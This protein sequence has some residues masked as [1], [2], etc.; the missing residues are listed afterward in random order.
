MKIAICFYGLPRYSEYTLSTLKKYLLDLYDI[1][2]YAHLWWSN[3]MIG[4]YK[5]RSSED[6]WEADT[7]DILK[8]KLHFK[9][10][11]TEPQIKFDIS[12]CKP[13]SPEPDLCHLPEIICKDTIF[14][15]VSKW[16]SVHKAFSLIDNVNDYDFIIM[17]RLDSDYSGPIDLSKLKPY[18]L[19]LQD[20]YRAGWDRKYDDVFAVGSPDVIKFFADI[21]KYIGKYHKNGLVHMH[22]YLDK[23]MNQ[24]IPVCHELYSFG[25]W[26]LHES[27]FKTRRKHIHLT[28]SIDLIK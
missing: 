22:L 3:E 7:I 18:I 25:V 27:L 2:I 10:L 16:H 21:Y 13:C 14:G 17:A 15:V 1:D 6:I 8:N 12:D 4:Q 26:Y 9:K 24:D 20:G 5:H 23:M 11:F 28:N 19:Y